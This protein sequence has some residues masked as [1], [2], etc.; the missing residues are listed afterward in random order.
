MVYRNAGEKMIPK[1]N[2]EYW[3]YTRDRHNFNIQKGLLTF[4]EIKEG[5]QEVKHEKYI[6]APIKASM[7]D[8]DDLIE[9]ATI[10]ETLNEAVESAYDNA[11]ALISYHEQQ[12]KNYQEQIND[13]FKYP[14]KQKVEVKKDGTE[15]NSNQD[16]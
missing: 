10:F 7:P 5:M 6:F 8:H 1:I 2:N 12:I 9:S 15:C 13:N 4:F 16:T 14:L 3:F 11:V